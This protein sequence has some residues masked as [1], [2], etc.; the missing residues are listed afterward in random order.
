MFCITESV[1]PDKKILTEIV[2][3]AGGKVIQKIPTSPVLKKLMSRKVS[4]THHFSVELFKQKIVVY[5]ISMQPPN[6]RLLL[7][8]CPTDEHLVMKWKQ[9]GIPV[10]NAEIILSGVLKQEV[11]E[12][13]YQL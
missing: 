1:V 11:N 9:E 8:S 10:H 2:E 6:N 7:V 3:C 5:F 4:V 12:T 13:A